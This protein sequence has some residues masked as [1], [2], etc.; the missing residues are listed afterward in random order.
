MCIQ[1]YLWIVLDCTKSLQQR[2]KIKIIPTVPELIFLK[3]MT[4]LDQLK[5]EPMFRSTRILVNN[6]EGTWIVH[7]VHLLL[8]FIFQFCVVQL[9]EPSPRHVI[10][11]CL[12]LIVQVT[13]L[14]AKT[15]EGPPPSFV[16][17]FERFFELTNVLQPCD[18]MWSV[19]SCV[20]ARGVSLYVCVYVSVHVSECVCV[21]VCNVHVSVCVCTCA[22]AQSLVWPSDVDL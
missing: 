8:W 18:C 16:K 3:T 19:R 17:P 2:H 7:W 6:I 11:P 5:K 12:F 14:R 15:K 4:K 20:C 1:Q 9:D 21:W 22:S 10:T 13:S